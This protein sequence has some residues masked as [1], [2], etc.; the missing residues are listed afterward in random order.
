[1]D[2]SC[3]GKWRPTISPELTSTAL[4]TGKRDGGPAIS[5]HMARG[6]YAPFRFGKEA[7][8]RQRGV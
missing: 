2:N 3:Y 6:R 1:M 4:L 7:Q 8:V 5:G